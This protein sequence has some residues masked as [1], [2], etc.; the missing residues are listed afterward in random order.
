M[1]PQTFRNSASVYCHYAAVTHQSP[2]FEG[3]GNNSLKGL[4]FFSFSNACDIMETSFFIPV[5][6]I[7]TKNFNPSSSYENWTNESAHTAI[8]WH[9]V[10]EI[11]ITLLEKQ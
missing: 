6:L 8:P 10:E 11:L 7:Y 9:E 2:E 3:V 4:R 1:V 5:H